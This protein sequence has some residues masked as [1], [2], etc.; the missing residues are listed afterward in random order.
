MAYQR[1]R[2]GSVR[3]LK[4]L[5]VSCSPVQF[6]LLAAADSFYSNIRL[7]IARL[8][9]HST[10]RSLRR[11]GSPDIQRADTEPEQ[12]DRTNN[13]PGTQKYMAPQL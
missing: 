3:G 7:E 8:G 6:E 2:L 5:L 13:R 10:I 12:N 9:R 1:E 11:N 4:A